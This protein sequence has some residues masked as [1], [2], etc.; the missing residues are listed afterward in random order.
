MKIL[1]IIAEYNPFHNG[2][3][4]MLEEAKKYDKFDA[5]ICVM[6]GNF[7]QRGEPAFCNKWTR[8]EMALH[9][10]VDLVIELPFSFAT[11]SAYFFAKGGV[12][13]LNRTGVTTHIA[14]GSESGNLSMLKKLAEL[15]SEEPQEYKFYLQE[16]LSQGLSFPSARAKALE[17]FLG[18]ED[19]ELITL[20]NKPNNILGIEYLRAILEENSLINPIT[21]NRVGSGYHSNQLSNYASATAIRNSLTKNNDFKTISHSLPESCLSLLKR[22]YK[23]GLAPVLPESFEQSLLVKL[24]SLSVRELNSIYEVTEGLEYRIQQAAYISKTL[25]ELR[26]NIKTKRYNLTKIN[27]M[28]LYTFFNLTK[29]QIEEF[30]KSGPLYLHILGF[31]SKGRKI[32]QEIKNNSEV[33]ILNRASDVKNIYEKENTTIKGKMI[34]LDILATDIYSI[35][36]PNSTQR[37]GRGDFTTSPIIVT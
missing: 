19:S 31:S 28:L 14:F 20:L 18:I 32:L 30:D 26:T 3:L 2:H 1:G 37:K 27:R 17:N 33:S 15:I 25:Q 5:V 4:H 12:Q 7:L 13:L 16:Y 23:L 36:Y 9:N 29:L 11:R 8:A 6:S 22:D 35:F 21:I 24:R 10:G 34:A